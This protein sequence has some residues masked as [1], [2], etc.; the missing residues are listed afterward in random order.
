MY[1][2]VQV[3]RLNREDIPFIIA[4]ECLC[5]KH[6]SGGAGSPSLHPKVSRGGHASVAWNIVFLLLGSS[7]I[8]GPL[9]YGGIGKIRAHLEAQVFSSLI[10]VALK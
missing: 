3:I 2:A 7:F 8:G 9:S 4:A 1:S 5:L 6:P 10:L